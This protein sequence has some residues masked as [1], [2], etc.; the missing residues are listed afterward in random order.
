MSLITSRIRILFVR[1]RIYVIVS[2]NVQNS[3]KIF[4]TSKKKHFCTI[5]LNNTS[6]WNTIMQW[7]SDK[8]RNILRKYFWYNKLLK[9]MAEFGKYVEV[10]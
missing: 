7:Y 10:S 9:F 5:I 1:V 2:I 4:F 3:K 6:F 8:H